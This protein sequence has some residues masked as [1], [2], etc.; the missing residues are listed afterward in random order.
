MRTGASDDRCP[1]SVGSVTAQRSP[2]G[3]WFRISDGYTSMFVERI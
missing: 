1:T 3:L 2:L